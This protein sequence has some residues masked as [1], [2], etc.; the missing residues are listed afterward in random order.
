MILPSNNI[1]QLSSS[2]WQE[3]FTSFG[4]D[5][6]LVYAMPWNKL[7]QELVAKDTNILLKNL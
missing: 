4:L 1:W 7:L 2:F 5:Y 6:V 3:S